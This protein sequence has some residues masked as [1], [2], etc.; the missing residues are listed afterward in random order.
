MSAAHNHHQLGE[1]H[2][3]QRARLAADLKNAA[4]GRPAAKAISNVRDY[5]AASGRA[6]GNFRQRSH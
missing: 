6:I 2:G 1:I 4:E 3:E 5:R